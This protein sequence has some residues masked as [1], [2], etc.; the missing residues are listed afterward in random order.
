MNNGEGLTGVF[1]KIIVEE[2]G[3]ATKSSMVKIL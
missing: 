1:D 3:G 2:R